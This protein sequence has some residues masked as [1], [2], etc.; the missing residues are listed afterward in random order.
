[1]LKVRAVAQQVSALTGS[2]SAAKGSHTWMRQDS[3]GSPNA[4]PTSS[5][6]PRPGNWTLT[7]EIQH[8][9]VDDGKVVQDDEDELVDVGESGVHSIEHFMGME[10]VLFR[11]EQRLV[12]ASMP[13]LRVGLGNKAEDGS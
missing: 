9:Y 13:Q 2:S 4:L 10:Q 1:M 3:Q 6:P 8:V 12:A 11:H 5:S 7:F